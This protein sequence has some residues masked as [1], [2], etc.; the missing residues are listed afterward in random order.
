MIPIIQKTDLSFFSELFFKVAVT[1][2]KMPAVRGDGMRGLEIHIFLPLAR[3]LRKFSHELY[4]KVSDFLLCKV[5][6]AA[7]QRDTC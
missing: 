1:G 6:N 2:V 7:L 3:I 5:G 4:C